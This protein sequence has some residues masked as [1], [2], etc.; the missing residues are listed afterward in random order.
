MTRLKCKI[1]WNYQKCI[2]MYSNLWF[3]VRNYNFTHS[4]KSLHHD[5]DPKKSQPILGSDPF[6][7]AEGSPSA[8]RAH[9]GHRDH[10]TRGH[11]RVPGVDSRAHVNPGSLDLVGPGTSMVPCGCQP[12]NR[13][14]SPKMDGENN[15]KAYEQMDD[16]GGKT[17]FLETPISRKLPKQFQKLQWQFGMIYGYS[18]GIWLCAGEVGYGSAT[19]A[20]TMRH[21]A[22]HCKIRKK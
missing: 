4:K 7:E 5:L 20:P 22:S 12:K 2:H 9:R 6:H 14:F 3:S 15:G 13:G 16:L 11:R 10:G 1:S 19:Y 17:L 18:F 21:H 8:A